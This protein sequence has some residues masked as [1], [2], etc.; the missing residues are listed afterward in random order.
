MGAGVSSSI[1]TIA[2]ILYATKIHAIVS[3]WRCQIISTM[4]YSKHCVSI[5]A[6][7]NQCDN[8]YSFKLWHNDIKELANDGSAVKFA[9]NFFHWSIWNLRYQMV[10][11]MLM[12]ELRMLIHNTKC[13]TWWWSVTTTFRPQ[14]LRSLLLLLSIRS[15]PFHLK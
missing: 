4:I 13:G 11:K 8:Y 7:C 15:S 3:S 9:N 2:W 10:K 14:I 12:S 1:L 5:V 6:N